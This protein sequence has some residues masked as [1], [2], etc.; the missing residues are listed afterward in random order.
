M[1]RTLEEFSLS[2]WPSLQ[3]I[4]YDGWVIRFANGHTRR[5]NSVSPI[6]PSTINVMEKIAYCEQA[7]RQRGQRVVFKISGAE[8]PTELDQLLEERGYEADAHTSVQT[9]DLPGLE[10]PTADAITVETSLSDSWVDNYCRL[11]NTAADRIPIVTQ[12]IQNIIPVCGFASLRQGEEIAS[13]GLAV[14]ERG[15]VGLYGIVTQPHLRNQGLGKQIMLHLMNWGRSQ[16]AERAYLQVMLNNP[17]ALHLYEKLG[18]QEEYTYW[19][20]VKD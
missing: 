7:Y 19:Y 8:Q 18:F 15:Y 5:A 12:I 1:I 2:A 10:Q 13:L 20:R 9:V 17:P 4:Y 14:V 3:V 6:Y 16:G 11:N